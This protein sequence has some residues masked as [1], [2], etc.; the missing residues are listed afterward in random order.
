MNLKPQ[1]TLKGYSA[2]A[3]NRLIFIEGWSLAEGAAWIIT[4]W[5]KENKELLDEEYE[6][7]VKRFL[8]ETKALEERR[9]QET[10]NR[11]GGG[12]GEDSA[13]Q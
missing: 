5:L 8:T 3:F 2:W 13:I 4:N 11:R 10:Q 1:P 7:S 6:I 9:K 12:T